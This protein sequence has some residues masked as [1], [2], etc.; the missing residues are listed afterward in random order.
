MRGLIQLATVSG[1]DTERLQTIP[2]NVYV[3]AESGAAVAIP[4]GMSLRSQGS[5]CHAGAPDSVSIRV[6]ASRVAGPLDIQTIS[7]QFEQSFDQHGLV[8]FPNPAFSYL[9]A[10]QRPD[11]LVT[12]RKSGIGS[13]RNSVRGLTF[14]TL[15]ARAT[16]FVGI[17]VTYI[18][19][20]QALWTQCMALPLSEP[21]CKVFHFQYD[22]WATFPPR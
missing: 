9:S 20:N 11:G 19:V 8:W 2:Y 3:E 22:Q 6:I 17:Q 7:V 12:N 1:F 21:S 10:M 4:T 5:E 13:D 16:L 15:M 18:G 14:E